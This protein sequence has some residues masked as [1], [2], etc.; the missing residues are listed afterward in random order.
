M[1]KELIKKT[2][3]GENLTKDESYALFTS[4]MEGEM[5]EAEIAAVLVAMRLTGEN[6][7]RDR[8]RFPCHEQCESQ[9]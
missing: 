8:R 1:S 7:R 4:I 5:S 9:V 6:T 2:G 3:M